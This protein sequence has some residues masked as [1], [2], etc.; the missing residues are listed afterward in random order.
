MLA[1]RKQNGGKTQPKMIKLVP[2]ISIMST[3]NDDNKPPSARH[4]LKYLITMVTN[5][6][7]YVSTI[8]FV[9]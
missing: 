6:N 1:E 8:I 5:V 3:I 2:K 4:S 9:C 7:A